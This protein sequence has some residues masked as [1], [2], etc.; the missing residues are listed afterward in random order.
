[1]KQ[2]DFL[3]MG[4]IGV[5]ITV[6]ANVFAI[7]A[8]ATG[9]PKPANPLPNVLFIAV[10]D[11]N[12]WIKTL[13]PANPIRTPNIDRLARRGMLF[14]RAYCS[15]PGCNPSRVS[16]LTGLSPSTTG[17]Y[18]NQTDWRR[19][20]PDAVTMPQH[21]MQHGYRV[22]GA[23]KIFHHHYNNAFH[24]K[25][26]FHDFR[27][28]PNPPDKPMPKIKL[29]GLLNWVGGRGGGPTSPP[30]DWG[31]WPAD[32]SKAVDV[33]TVDWVLERLARPR[34]QPLFMAVGL[35]RPHMPF[36]APKKYFDSYPLDEVIMPEV[37]E[38]DLDDIPTGG[39]T[40][41]K[42]AKPFIYKTILA[43]EANRPGTLK[44]AVRAYQACATFADV[45]IGRL[46]DG[47][48]AS[49]HS[50]NTIIV[51]WS[52]HGFHLG[53]KQHWEKFVL[54]EKAT[55]IP[56]LIVAP[57]ITQGGTRCDRPV[58]SLDI[59]P[60]LIELCGLKSRSELEGVSLMPLLKDPQA[61]WDRPA[62]MTYYR[63]NHAVRSQWWRYIRY[64]DGSEELYDHQAD[65]NEWHNLASKPDL[66]GVIEK[67]KRWLPKKN[68]PQAADMPPRE[69]LGPPRKYPR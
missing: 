16:M 47:L 29:N 40:M 11:L 50:G 15:S 58:S 13:D 42:N 36:F 56:F 7:P 45:Q 20:L 27:F 17:V 65:P 66:A 3:Q 14:T 61:V 49:P 52:D 8:L 31:P 34:Q 48:A 23:G 67:L 19:A 10:D 39:R 64:A 24:D 68:A 6:L 21:F 35:F 1:M 2:C 18:G 62:V 53:E 4:L 28:M 51:L 38:D 55:R 60:T 41:L 32:E 54:W 57:G 25:A 9:S 26:S 30:F 33:Q 5:V 46:L 63:N 69:G 37:L 22:E 12:D 44:E 59:Y 43:G